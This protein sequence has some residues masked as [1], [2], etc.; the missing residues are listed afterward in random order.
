MKMENIRQK[1]LADQIKKQVSQII[2]HKLKDPRKGFITI[3]G[4]K[5]SRDLRIASIY[6]TTLGEKEQ[7]ERSRETLDRGKNF[8]RSE[9]APNLKLRFTPELRFFY[10][11]SLEYSEHIENL[12]KKIHSQD[13]DKK[14]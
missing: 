11:E 8:I 7:R 3:T 12:L 2:N 14:E 6:F 5:I 1:K 10:D 4:V 9:L 13:S